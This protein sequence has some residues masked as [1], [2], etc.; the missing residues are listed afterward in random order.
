M[1]RLYTLSQTF[2][3]GDFIA[4]DIRAV[5]DANVRAAAA[6]VIE[7]GGLSGELEKVF[8]LRMNTPAI[9]D[10]DFGGSV[11]SMNPDEFMPYVKPKAPVIVGFD[12]V[13]VSSAQY[14]LKPEKEYATEISV[15]DDFD[16][17]GLDVGIPDLA[18]IEQAADLVQED[19]VIEIPEVA[20][21]NAN[22]LKVR[23]DTLRFNQKLWRRVR[24]IAIIA[25]IVIVEAIL[26]VYL[27]TP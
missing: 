6:D 2:D 22:L 13:T 20:R 25:A 18:M 9:P 27:L 4:P 23:F 21:Y 19:I 10:D 14:D 15:D 11:P 24:L 12:S 16:S 7:S 17:V 5:V 3:I 1:T 8:V 26:I